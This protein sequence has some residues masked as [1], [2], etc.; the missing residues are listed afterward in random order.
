MRIL[1]IL[2]SPAAGVSEIYA[3]D[4]MRGLHQAGIEQQVVM[5]ENGMLYGELARAGLVLAPQI[6]H[7]RYAFSRRWRLRRLIARTKPDIIQYW[8]RPDAALLPSTKIPL[9]GWSAGY[10][11]PERFTDFRF[12]VTPTT[13]IAEY[14]KKRGVSPER[15]RVIPF[16][17]TMPTGAPMDRHLLAT[18]REAKIIL[19]LSPLH[20]DQGFDALFTALQSLPDAYLWLGEDGPSR[21]SLETFVQNLGLGERVRFLGHRADR[22][23]LLRAADVLVLPARREIYAL[24]VIEAW[25]AGTPVIAATSQGPA[26]LIVDKASGLLI[27]PDNAEALQTAL[28]Q[29]FADKNLCQRVVAKGYAA[30]AKSHAR[31]AVIRQW[32]E[33]YR[34]LAV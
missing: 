6:L 25:A 31:E 23:A 24:P 29:I 30:F 19:S 32:M 21:R 27:P 17:A 3:A 13:G 2:T 8:M 14:M 12:I 18:P 22:G 34:L 15:L 20:P 10:D 33:F 1:H 5:P 26:G 28:E 7:P 16:S 4:I 9:V 11:D